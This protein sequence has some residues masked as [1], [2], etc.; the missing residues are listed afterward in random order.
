MQAAF[1]A[2]FIK[3]SQKMCFFTLVG[4]RGCAIK[5]Q[6]LSGESKTSLDGGFDRWDLQNN[7]LNASFSIFL[8]G[9]THKASN[10]QHFCC[11][12]HVRVVEKIFSNFKN[13]V[14]EIML[15]STFKWHGGRLGKFWGP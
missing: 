11:I 15:L 9:S 7:A 1:L 8:I 6:N 12:L 2:K 10:F 3:K 13:L 14:F 4:H 5:S